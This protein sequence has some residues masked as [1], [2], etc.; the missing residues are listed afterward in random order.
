MRAAPLILDR[1]ERLTGMS[2]KRE[3]GL[4]SATS[5]GIGGILGAGIFVLSGVAISE[6][7][8]AA[9]LSFVIG[10]LLSLMIGFSYITLS[11]AF[12]GEG[13]AY[14]YAAKSYSHRYSFL[15]GWIYFGAWIIASGYVTL[16]FGEYVHSMTGLPAI[17]VGVAL[18]VVLTGMNLLGVKI[19]GWFQTALIVAELVLLVLVFGAGLP[20]I[21][22]G[23]F[24]PI[25]PNGLHPMLSA[26]LLGF[27]SLTGWDV[28]AVASKEIKNAN[29]NVPLSIFASIMVVSVVYIALVFVMVGL[30]PYQSYTGNAAPVVMAVSKVFGN[31]ISTILVGCIV[32]IALVATTNSFIMV[33]SRTLHALSSNTGFPRF[34]SWTS[35]IGV[36][37]VSILVVNLLKT[38]VLIL[39]NLGLYT[40]GTGFL[41]LVSFI[42][43]LLCLPPFNRSFPIRV[44]R[45]Y[46]ILTVLSVLLS[47]FVLVNNT[48][49]GTIYGV[50][51][52]LIG[53]V[54]YSIWGKAIS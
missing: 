17:P 24:H 2:F 42:L 48:K 32:S 3:L 21:N 10:A 27:L 13:G 41:Y 51:W 40:G 36:P 20:H 45:I 14:Y 29:K 43:T 7:G 18:I 11:K 19:S 9:I 35:N 33:T 23:N 1:L 53:L 22:I 37:W 5:L 38:I 46:Q 50:L 8:P 44:K 28:I 31:H 26:S 16:G 12:P 54:L 47:L 49:E 39:G 6:A 30:Y 34:L 52:V 25:L 15:T 4:L